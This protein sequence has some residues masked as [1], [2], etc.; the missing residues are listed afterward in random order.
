MD[1][2]DGR[3]TFMVFV[4]KG[5]EWIAEDEIKKKLPDASIVQKSDKRIVFSADSVSFEDLSNL[6]TVD[7]VHILLQQPAEIK[8]LSE[9]SVVENLPVDKI[10]EAKDFIGGF[11]RLDD[12]FSITLSRYKN[13]EIDLDALESKLSK[14]IADRLKMRYTAMNHENFDIRVHIE[15]SSLFFSCR[16]SRISSYVRSYR[17]CE[18]EGSLRPPIAAALCMLAD[19][20]PQH[21]LVDNFC[22]TGTI[23]CEALLQGLDPYGGDID[24][25]AVR[26]AAKN[27]KGLSK[28]SARNLRVLDA[29]ASKWQSGY[30]DYAISNYPWGKQVLL[31][32]IVRLYTNSI[33]EYA[34]ILKKSGTL[35]LLG[36]NPDLMVKHVKKNFP[37]HQITKFRIGFLGETPWVVCAKPKIE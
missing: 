4:T 1:C 25:E 37:N 3:R 36:I 12:T 24:E 6:R 18:R 5:L 16:L 17:V 7:D 30:F 27:M 22:G 32:G 19:P 31:T 13:K 14:I 35:V 23:L 2:Q 9:Q 20:E 11:R 21:R 10:N 34:R 15:S 28:E 29:A 8:G 33:A 26:C